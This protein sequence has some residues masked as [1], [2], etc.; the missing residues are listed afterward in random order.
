MYSC[1]PAHVY[2]LTHTH[3]SAH[4]NTHTHIRNR[5]VYV[6]KTGK[7]PQ[8]VSFGGGLDS[9]FFCLAA[10]GTVMIHERAHM[11]THTYTLS[12]SLCFFLSVCP[13]LSRCLSRA[14]TRTHTRLQAHAL[15]LPPARSFPLCLHIKTKSQHVEL[16]EVLRLAPVAYR[17]LFDVIWGSLNRILGSFDVWYDVGLF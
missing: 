4:T 11:R 13:S 7:P 9:T 1:S 3:T 5:I 10:H 16:A 15:S 8:I 14:G 2:M 17:A 6:Y 12:L